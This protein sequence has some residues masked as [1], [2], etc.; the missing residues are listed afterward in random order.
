MVSLDLA[1]KLRFERAN[2]CARVKNGS[3]PVAFLIMNNPRCLHT[4][5]VGALLAK[6][7]RWGKKRA[8]RLL[9]RIDIKESREIGKLTWRQRNALADALGNRDID[10][11]KEMR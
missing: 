7:S 6:Q 1:N 9:T 4:M 8:R 3:L 10:W 11:T 2:M 5:T